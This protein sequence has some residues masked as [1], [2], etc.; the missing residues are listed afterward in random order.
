M[1]HPPKDEEAALDALHRRFALPEAYRAVVDAVA[2]PLAGRI[3]AE[4]VRAGRPIVVGLCGSQGSGKSTL[5]AFVAVLLEGRGL[6]VAGLS[7][8]DLYLSRR[9]RRELAAA[10]H[11]LL[12]ARGPPGT[13]D[14]A[15]GLEVLDALTRVDGSARQVAL[16]RFDKADD[17][18]RDRA[19]WPQVRAPVDVVLFEGWFVGARPQPQAELEAPV[20]ALERDEDAAGVWRRHVD[21]ALAGDYQ[22]LFARIALLVLLKA[23]SFER[24]YAWRAL[25][26]KKLAATLEAEGRTGAVMDPPAL[27]RFIAHYERLTRWILREMPARADVVVRLGSAHE[28]LEVAGL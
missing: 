3:A 14:V 1:P 13:H 28:V 11:P 24:V 7:V 2:R 17:A 4:Q 22:A 25:Q 21:A 8:D 27:R 19:A 12:A 26:E 5:A 23:P 10:H 18:R 15:L 20:N 6:S 9:E 16:P